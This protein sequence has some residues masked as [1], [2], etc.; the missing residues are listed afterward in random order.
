MFPLPLTFQGRSGFDGLHGETGNVG[1]QVGRTA[2]GMYFTCFCGR[3]RYSGVK[4]G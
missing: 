2:R 3:E 4:I 1:R